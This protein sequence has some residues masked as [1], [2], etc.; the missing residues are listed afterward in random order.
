[1]IPITY[2]KGDATL[3]QGEG[4]KIIAHVCND[5][6]AWGAGFSGALSKRYPAAEVTYRKAY[7]EDWPPLGAVYI[8]NVTSTFWVANMIAQ[9]GVRKNWLDKPPIRY[10]A[11]AT[12]FICVS[13]QAKELK[14]S[15]HMP[16]IG[17]GLAGGRWEEIEP[18]IVDGLSTYD[19]PVFIYDL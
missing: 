5:I 1:M 18:L 13:Y 2:L 14:A 11:I 16:R 3:P 19:V 6:G 10:D 7:R 9:H 8:V 4:P 17:C 12:A 15:V